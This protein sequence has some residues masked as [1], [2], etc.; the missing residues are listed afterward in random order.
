[1]EINTEKGTDSLRQSLINHSWGKQDKTVGKELV[2]NA[3]QWT[4]QLQ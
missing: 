2:R 1:M 3:L 4:S